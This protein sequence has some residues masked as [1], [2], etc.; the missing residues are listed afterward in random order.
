MTPQ[1]TDGVRLVEMD[2]TTYRGYRKHLVRDYANDKSRAGVWSKTKAEDKAADEVDGLLP[3][4]PATQDHFLYSVRDESVPAEVGVLWISTRDSGAGRSIWI[5]DIIVHQQFRRM[6][7]AR[8]TLHLVENKARE[9]GAQKIEL[10]VFGHNH[11]AR[12]LYEQL[13][14]EA[15][16]IVMAKPL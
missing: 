16:S 7:Y 15:T 4:G 11:G 8:R 12:A 6:G 9:L 13:G 10:H 14:Y 2:E 5:Y 1:G 3:E